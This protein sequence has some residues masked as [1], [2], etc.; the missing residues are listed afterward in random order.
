VSGL[1]V[2]HERF[3]GVPGV[4]AITLASWH[5]AARPLL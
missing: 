3:W 5:R 4:Y 1:S 2:V